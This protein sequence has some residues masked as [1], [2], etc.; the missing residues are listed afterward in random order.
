MYLAAL[1]IGNITIVD[2]DK[3]ELSNL[4]R[5]IIHNTEKIGVFK[6]DSAANFVNKLN[7]DINV[8]SITEKFSY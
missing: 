4:Q 2:H 8:N 3:I 5:Q 6:S 7:P 1:G